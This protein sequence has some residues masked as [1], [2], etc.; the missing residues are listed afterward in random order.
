VNKQDAKEILLLYRPSA[1]GDDP[2]FSEALALTRTDPELAAWFQ[3]HCAFQD[4][5]RAA[6]NEIPVPEALKE[7][8]LSERKAHITLSS[9]RKALAAASV[10]VILAC[11]GVFAFRNLPHN[12]ALDNS[13]A[14]FQSRMIGLILRYPKMDL[15]TN[16]LQA[17][18]QE[19]AKHGQTNIIFTASLDK[20]AGTGCATLRWQDKPVSMICFNSGKNGKPK[21]PDLFLFAIDTASLKDPPPNGPDGPLITQARKSLFSGSWTSGGKTYVLGAIGD[22]NFLRQYF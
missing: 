4:A 21:T 10:V 11:I 3:Q 20:T 13:F 9:R 15:E 12:P 7:Q 22:E 17:I 14:N 8:I 2:E 18:R 1:D 6:F 16:D 5:A 19:L